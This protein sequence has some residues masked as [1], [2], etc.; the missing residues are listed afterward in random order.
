MDKGRHTGMIMIDLQKVFDTLDHNVL[1]EKMKC[2]GFKK[3]VIERFKSY[4]SNRKIFCIAGS[5]FS[6]RINHKWSSTRPYSVTTPFLN[7]Y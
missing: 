4:L 7:I 6:R 2:M 3:P 5:L 1:L